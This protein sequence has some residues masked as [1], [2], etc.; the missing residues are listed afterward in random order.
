MSKLNDFR[1][2]L[3]N[4]VEKKSSWGK[5]QLVVLIN[6]AFAEIVEKPEVTNNKDEDKR[7]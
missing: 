4:K 2:N 1:K 7:P 3:L 5:N 6:E